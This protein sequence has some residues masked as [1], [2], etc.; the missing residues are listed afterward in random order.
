MEDE[1]NGSENERAGEPG[2][3][4]DYVSQLLRLKRY[5]SPKQEYFEGFLTQFQTRQR[6]EMLS[7]SARGLL[8][9]RVGTWWWGLGKARWVYGAGAASVAA[10]VIGVAVNSA[11]SEGNGT[12]PENVAGSASTTIL[13]LNLPD[14]KNTEG[15]LPSASSNTRTND[16]TNGFVPVSTGVLQEL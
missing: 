10:A 11:T 13:E 5:E 12:V 9:E 8:A 14:G 6:Q 1:V 7:Q 15:R 4:S 2:P 16:R 3:E